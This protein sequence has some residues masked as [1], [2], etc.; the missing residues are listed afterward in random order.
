MDPSGIPSKT[1]DA[2]GKPW[3]WTVWGSKRSGRTA[4]LTF[5]SVR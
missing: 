3:K 5:V 2:C 1:D 4:K